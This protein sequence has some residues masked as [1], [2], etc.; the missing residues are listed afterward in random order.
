MDAATIKIIEKFDSQRV[1]SAIYFDKSKKQ[2][3]FKRF[4]I[5]TV[6]IKTKFLF[7]KEGEGNI[8][9]EVTT[10]L[11]PILKVNMPKS[12]ELPTAKYKINKAEVV[13]WKN[14][15][16]KFLDYVRGM[17]MEWVHRGENEQAKLF[18]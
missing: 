10:D 2:Y 13:S 12:S 6:T 4:K 1:I 16:I 14:V 3:N 11:D 17:K 7:I 5:E 9:S 8:L 18:D 15:G